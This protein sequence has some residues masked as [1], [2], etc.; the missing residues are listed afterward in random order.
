MGID[1]D[2]PDCRSDAKEQM[3]EL[4]NATGLPGMGLPWSHGIDA[5]RV[6]DSSIQ[7]PS[8]EAAAAALFKAAENSDDEAAEHPVEDPGTLQTWGSLDTVE[9]IEKNGMPVNSTQV[10]ADKMAQKTVGPN[11]YSDLPKMYNKFAHHQSMNKDEFAAFLQ[12]GLN[13][14]LGKDDV[15]ALVHKLGAGKD[16]SIDFQKIAELAHPSDYPRK[17][18]KYE[19]VL[20]LTHPSDAIAQKPA[21]LETRAPDGLTTNAPIDPVLGMVSKAKQK[22]EGAKSAEG[23]ELQALLASFKH[24]DLANSGTLTAEQIGQVLDR[25]TLP[26]SQTSRFLDMLGENEREVIDYRSLCK[27]VRFAGGEPTAWVSKHWYDLSFLVFHVCR[28]WRLALHKR[29]NSSGWSLSAKSRQY[30][31]A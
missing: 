16:G 5:N 14:N 4:L 9:P 21:P 31:K 19:G 3:W 6:F 2:L 11:Q 18:G 22:S 1:P 10:M 8:S 28:S 30:Q 29:A 23:A 20:T 26:V 27:K 13:T 17:D 12:E 24:F 7:A 25:L 15:D